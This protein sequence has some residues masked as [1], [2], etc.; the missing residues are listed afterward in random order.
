M[1]NSVYGKTIENL[2]KRDSV[3]ICRTK[4]ELLQEV[5]KSTYKRQIIVNEEMV[6][7]M[8]RRT[9]I[10]YNKPFYIGFSILDISKYIMYDY[11]YNVL[12]K[13]YKNHNDLQLLYSD[14][15]SLVLKIKT[16]ELISDLK[17]LSSTFDFS[18]LPEDHELYDTGKKSKLFCFK[19]E[20]GLRP[21]LRIV[22]LASKVYAFQIA[23]CHNFKHHYPGKCQMSSPNIPDANNL[24]GNNVFF[25]D[26]LTMKGV[27][28]RA[29]NKF[30]FEDYFRCLQSQ[31]SR[32]TVDY[33][34]QSKKQNLSS[35][36]IQK[37][38]LSGFDDKRYI[39]DC[40]LHSVPYGYSLHSNK[41][42]ASE[43]K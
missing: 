36:V 21:I 38:A 8:H 29:K 3:K 2:S 13:Y 9:I 1:V 40:G 11:F 42:F 6:I 33:R 30:T 12:R 32:R 15:D 24:E 14:T 41:C 18:N 4:E 23:C 10:Y 39:L 26:K 43:C 37:V 34:I 35:I 7:V 25:E 31:V 16:D 19:E 17:N 20:F 28:Q 5:S 27:S 22:S